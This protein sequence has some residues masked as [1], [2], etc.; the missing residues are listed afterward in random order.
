MNLTGQT[1]EA[2]AA[3]ALVRE[4]FEVSAPIFTSPAFDLVAKW[5][6][7]IHAIQV[8]TGCVSANGK[9][10][11]WHTTKSAGGLYAEGD[12]SY[13]GLVL[14]PHNEVWWVPFEEV[15]GKKSICTN[16]EHDSLA[17]YRGSLD[18]LKA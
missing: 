13:F 12:C 1:A 11:Q 14:I 16:I 5:G 8:K 18:A 17:E 9:T 3:L 10:V 6:R 7:A 2:V 4:G 15:T